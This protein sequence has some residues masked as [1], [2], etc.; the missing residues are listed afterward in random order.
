MPFLNEQRFYEIHKDFHPPSRKTPAIFLDRDGVVIVEKHYLKD[1]EEVELYPGV[2]EKFESLSR[3]KVPVVLV[4]NQSGIGQGL[5]GWADYQRVHQRMLELLGMDQPFT[6]VYANGHHPAETQASWRKPN[7]GMMLQ[8]ASDMN[9]ALASSVMVGDKWVDL[10]AAARAGISRLIHVRTG[11]GV[12]EVAAVM[13][14]FPQAVTIDSLARLD[15]DIF[16]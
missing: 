7:P 4:T 1:P 3:L 8:A 2:A 12:I 14:D 5:F 10:E 11:Y 15:L 13:K 16:K 9:L 6:A